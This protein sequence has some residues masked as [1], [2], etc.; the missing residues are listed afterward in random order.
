MNTQEAFIFLFSDIFFGNF[1]LSTN[2]ELALHVMVSFGGYNKVLMFFVSISSSIC[3]TIANYGCGIVLFNL[4]KYSSEQKV[5]NN[6]DKLVV[7]FN[8]Y[9]CYLLLLSMIQPIGRITSII[10]GFVK[11]DITK[12]FLFIIISKTVYYLYILYL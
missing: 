3:A 9:M 12:T 6:Y 4:Y 10:A 11:F 2:N 5:R 1:I 8:K 7:F